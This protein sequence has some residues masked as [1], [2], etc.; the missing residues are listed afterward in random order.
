[1]C[2]IDVVILVLFRKEKELENSRAKWEEQEREKR[3]RKQEAEN[4]RRRRMEEQEEEAARRREQ[5]RQE[6]MKTRYYEVGLGRRIQA[7]LWSLYRSV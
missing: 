1:M 5:R 6:I 3:R 2:L 7:K 4:A